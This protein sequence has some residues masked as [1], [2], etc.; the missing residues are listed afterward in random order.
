MSVW[1]AESAVTVSI[2]LLVG[3]IGSLALRRQSAAFRHWV[4]AVTVMCACIAVPARLVL[5]TWSELP[6][7]QAG[8]GAS[9]L[10]A[11]LTI[12]NNGAAAIPPAAG[13]SR[14]EYSVSGLRQQVIG[15]S[16]TPSITALAMVWM[17]G[18]VASCL[19]L[20]LGLARLRLIAAS[21]ETV[22]NH[23]WYTLVDEIRAA[24]A[25]ER[26]IRLL[27]SDHPA[28]LMAWGW[29]RPTILVP[30]IAH[31]WTR[32]RIEVVLAHEV[33]HLARHDSL[34]QIAVAVLRALYWFNPVV[35]FA[36]ARLRAESEQA[37]DDAV[38]HRG[39]DGAAYARHLVAIARAAH[40]GLVRGALLPASAM[41][42]PSQ[43]EARIKAMLNRNANRRP[44]AR[45]ARSITASI[46]L[47]LTL[48][49]AG[50]RA[51]S[52]YHKLSGTVVD[53]T[54][55][56]LPGATLVLTN[57]ARDAKYEVH[58]DASG[59][60][61]FVGLPPGAYVL[62][63]S[64]L[65]FATLTLGD[66]SVAGDV[67]RDLQMHVGSVEEHITVS[68]NGTPPPL[69]AA[70]LERREASRR[71]AAE[72]LQAALTQCATT[73]PTTVGGNILPP[74]KVVDV[75]PV[76]PEELR[77][78]GIGGTI[79]MDAVIGTDGVVRDVQ[80]VAGTDPGLEA[81]AVEA[82]RQWEFTPTLLNCDP[83]DVTMRVTVNFAVQ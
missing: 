37:C 48:C 8:R 59:R 42:R 12:V 46:L 21:A 49:M 4:L 14:D 65:G 81:A 16:R 28:L 54:G 26:S 56:V 40:A 44:P 31:R 61:E 10:T 6:P 80:N 9:P 55:R 66:I 41:A 38:L 77:A 11:A 52:A 27:Q 7:W 50:V 1:M 79:T 64:Q 53:T 69:D 24:Y 5:P 23:E 29:R 82:V 70:A 72:R 18:T 20:L 78:A 17:L 22:Q 75:R 2:I 57:A 63:A 36:A 58:S 32:E 73:P 68:S 35:W 83:I 19:V 51:Q 71:R 39:V 43:L 67:Q 34:W 30:N 25:F 45:L 33:A 47:T 15:A 60:F 13:T 74:T 62:K 76:Y 3:L